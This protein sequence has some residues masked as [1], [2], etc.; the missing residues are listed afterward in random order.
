MTRYGQSV[1]GWAELSTINAGNVNGLMIG[2]DSAKPIVFGTSDLERMRIDASG[3]VGIGVTST[4]HKL[5][6]AGNIKASGRL[7]DNDHYV[8]TVTVPDGWAVGDYFEVVRASPSAAGASSQW[9]VVVS[10][11]RNSWTESHLYRAVAGHSDMS[12]WLEVPHISD[13]TYE[14]A[15]KCFTLDINGNTSTPQFR[16]RA[17]KASASCGVSGTTLP[18]IVKIRSIG[19]NTAWTDMSGTGNDLTVSGFKSQG[20]DWSLYTGKPVDAAGVLAMHATSSGSVGIGTKNPLVKLGVAGDITS[21]GGSL[22]LQRPVTGG[23]WARGI[24]YTPDGSVNPTGDGLAGIGI[25][26]TGTTQSSIFLTH[27]VAPWNSTVGMHILSNGSVA[28]GQSSA[29]YKLHVNGAVAGTSAFVNTSDE[30][31]KKDIKKIKSASD[32]LRKLNGVE[33]I[34]RNDEFPDKE[35]K[36]G[37]DIGVIAQNVLDVFPEAVEIDQDGY[38]SV[39][40]SKLVAPLIEAFKEMDDNQKKLDL[41]MNGSLQKIE[42]NSREIT[43]LKNEVSKQNEKIDLLTKENQMLKEALCSIKESLVFCEKN[44]Q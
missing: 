7:I 26:G 24:M 1:A 27:G 8:K 5:E 10:G 29:S 43:S 13:N 35:F 39:A 16:L 17:I 19:Y 2:N 6:V 44:V 37:Q 9:E 42:T 41:M 21:A 11:T 18:L 22:I 14:G 40:Y 38:Y 12:G 25:Y 3:N 34:W 28:I 20:L 15:S 32:K 4:S 30:R 33:F 31:Y 36:Q 23:G